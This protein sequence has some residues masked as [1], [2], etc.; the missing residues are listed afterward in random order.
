MSLLRESQPDDQQL[1]RYLLRL[2]PEEE[3]ERLDE[4]SIADEQTAWRLRVAENDLVDA[5][6]SGT[7]TGA[8]LERFESHFLSTE[9]RRDKVTFARSLRTA[10]SSREI[11]TAPAVAAPVRTWWGLAAAAAI[12]LA[13]GGTLVW[14]DAGLRTELD[15]ARKQTAALD[16]QA[17]DLEQQLQNGRAATVATGHELAP[18][19]ANLA[20]QSSSR[21]TA[22]AP[23][24]VALVL[25]PQMRSVST[26][27]ELILPPGIDRVAFDLRLESNRFPRYQVVL[28]DP[29]TGQ[30]VWRSGE[31]IVHQVDDQATVSGVFPANVLKLQHY[32]IEV[33]GRADGDEEFVGSY[34]FQ[35]VGR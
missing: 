29:A 23:S 14:Q 1:V 22:P 18:V 16:R 21:T 35:I 30:T 15:Q 24:T 27:Q 34:A 20:T 2:L 8:T 3:A 6:V 4:M 7:L 9:R 26:I 32:S 17:R 13:A 12:V 33:T 28:K 10:A 11:R 5:Y 25:L 31:L 19:H